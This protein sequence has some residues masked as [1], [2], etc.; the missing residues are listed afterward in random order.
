[1]LK[2][3]RMKINAIV[4]P[5]CSAIVWFWPAYGLHVFLFICAWVMFGFWRINREMKRDEKALEL[6]M[7]MMESEMANHQ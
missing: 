2:S 4:V 1:M 7:Q 5:V 6:E 3:A